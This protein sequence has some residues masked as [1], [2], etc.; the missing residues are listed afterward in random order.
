[1]EALRLVLYQETANYK[2]PTA[3][4]VGET[5]P[6][7]PLS[8]V[9]GMLHALMNATEF[10]PLHVGVQGTYD[11]RMVD[12]QRHYF[13]KKKDMPE[14]PLVI[15]GLGFDHWVHRG[16]TLTTMPLYMH[17]LYNIQLIIHVYAEHDVLTR[18]E[19]GVKSGVPISLGRWEDLVRIDECT[20]VTLEK[21]PME[22]IKTTNDMFV[23]TSVRKVRQAI[24]YRMNWK[25]IIRQGVRQWERLDA[26]YLKKDV[27]IAGRSVWMDHA[28]NDIPVAFFPEMGE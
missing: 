6:L 7:P 15:D 2:K 12:Y 1:M 26:Y 19:E 22:G 20:R 8:T 18:I 25:Y 9:K 16:D 13:F 4:K 11:S 10:V 24:P 27:N 21:A 5:Y 3:A 23:P 17:L 14:F 28:G